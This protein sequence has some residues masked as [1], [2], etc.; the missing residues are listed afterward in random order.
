MR[1]LGYPPGW[2]KAADMTKTVVA[3]IDGSQGDDEVPSQE[4]KTYNV[5]Q[6]VVYPGFNAPLPE[7]VKDDYRSLRMPPMQLHQQLSFATSTMKKPKPIPYTKFKL[8]DSSS[9]LDLSLNSTMNDPVK[10]EPPSGQPEVV[11]TRKVVSIGIP[12]PDSYVKAKKPPL[13][14]WSENNSLADLIY[15]ENLPT[16]TGVFDKMRGVLGGIRTRLSSCQL[17]SSIIGSV[18]TLETSVEQEDNAS[19]ECFA[20]SQAD[21][22]ESLAKMSSKFDSSFDHD[23]LIEVQEEGEI[24][25]E[26]MDLPDLSRNEDD[27][28]QEV[29]HL[30][31]VSDEEQD[32]DE[33][34]HLSSSISY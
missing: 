5:E 8:N 19:I 14:K 12:I 6:L 2:L 31:K 29:E 26:A 25:D 15:F 32:T 24:R 16:S 1:V 10:N 30:A 4:D 17:D 23:D 3:I 27:D 28:V 33:V 18:A 11:K 21:D 20:S 13:E 9:Q 22:T 7:G 34:V